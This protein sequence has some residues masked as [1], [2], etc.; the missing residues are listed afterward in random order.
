MSMSNIVLVRNMYSSEKTLQMCYATYQYVSSMV[1]FVIL[2]AD[3]AI[4][5]KSRSSRSSRT[6]ASWTRRR[7][8]VP[9]YITP[10]GSTRVC[11]SHFPL[12]R[13]SAGRNAVSTTVVLYLFLA[14]IINP[15]GVGLFIIIVLTLRACPHCESIC[16]SAPSGSFLQV[17]QV[18]PSFSRDRDAAGLVQIPP[19]PRRV[20]LV[21]LALF[22]Y[23]FITDIPSQSVLASSVATYNGFI[24]AYSLP[25]LPYTCRLFTLP[26]VGTSVYC[27]RRFLCNRANQFVLCSDVAYRSCTASVLSDSRTESVN[28]HL[29]FDFSASSQR[30][31]RICP[32]D[33][34]SCTTAPWR[35]HDR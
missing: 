14:L 28:A 24:C 32:T 22:M 23:M 34:C 33:F 16:L 29:I 7:H 25:P 6:P 31:V 1:L 15:R 20:P 19:R 10:T 8:G 3:S 30:G 9:R 11:L 26:A 2:L 21:V 4:G 5:A 35:A 27:Y 18:K 13:I 17:L 12:R